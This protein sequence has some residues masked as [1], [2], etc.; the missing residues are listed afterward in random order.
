VA[1]LKLVIL[2][3]PATKKTSN[4][5]MRNKKT[6][7]PFVMP[8][9]KSKDW[10]K[11]AI[12][13]LNRLGR[14]AP[15][16]GAAGNR[17]MTPLVITRPVSVNAQIYRDRNTGDL[18]NFFQAIGDA[19]QGGGSKNKRVPCVL[20]DDS[21]IKSWDGSRC[22]IDKANPRVELTIEPMEDEG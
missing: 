4:R 22:R 12:D 3:K 20:A 21:Q 7:A 17:G 15:L 6:N 14:P 5:I 16:D 19:L 9:K 8:S 13:Q 10:E 1:T 18:H 2:G 11:N